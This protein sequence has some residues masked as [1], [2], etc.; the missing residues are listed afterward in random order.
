MK[1]NVVAPIGIGFVVVANSPIF[2]TF[3]T[4]P[5]IAGDL[6]AVQIGGCLVGRFVGVRLQKGGRHGPDPAEKGTAGYF[7]RRL[8]Q[9]NAVGFEVEFAGFFGKDG[10]GVGKG[11][12]V[13][14]VV[15]Q[16]CLRA[17][18]QEFVIEHGGS[19][20]DVRGKSRM[21]PKW[22]TELPGPNGAFVVGGTNAGI[23]R[24]EPKQQ[25]QH[26]W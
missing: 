3:G 25:Q 16:L 11:E 13:F 4:F 18:L 23:G 24:G 20:F 2:K 15:D 17:V 21:Q 10:M 26:E 7:M 19:V 22:G 1:D 9:V 14:F 5:I 8:G 12:T 6:I